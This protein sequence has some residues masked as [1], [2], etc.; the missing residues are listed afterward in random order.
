MLEDVRANARR[1][2]LVLIGL[3][4][5]L[6]LALGYWQVVRGSE[7]A[8]DPANP[9]V[10]TA[11]QSEP[12][13]RILDRN[14]VVLAEGTPRHYAD[15]SL[16]HTVGFHSD[17]YGD[18]DLEAAYDA[19]LRGERALSPLERLAQVL[20]HT[21]PTPNDLVLTVD[22]RIHDAAIQALGSSAGSIV[23]IDPRSGEVLAMA[24]TPYFDPNTADAQMGRLLSDQ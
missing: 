17:R 1:A 7:L 22:K 14:G 2:A 19:E 3:F 15:A 10:A 4:G 13:G 5:V 21:E 12:R 6:S 18:T 16:V 8:K 9:R 11:R 20:L 23:A 24:S